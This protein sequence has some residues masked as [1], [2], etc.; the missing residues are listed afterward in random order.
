MIF[1]AI[2]LIVPENIELT[3]RPSLRLFFLS[4]GIAALLALTIGIAAVGLKVKLVILIALVF[5]SWQVLRVHAFLHSS[6][7][8]AHLIYE[9]SSADTILV[10]DRNDETTRYRLQG[11]TFVHPQLTILALRP[12]SGSWRFRYWI[13]R[14]VM[15]CPDNCEPVAFRRLRASLLHRA[16]R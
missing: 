4:F 9:A 13:P 7:S 10:T 6:D 8:P 11:S 14:C 2:T 15:L 5:Y 1:F 3:L 12:V 16:L